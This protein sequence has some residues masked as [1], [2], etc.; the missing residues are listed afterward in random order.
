MKKQ[1]PMGKTIESNEIQKVNDAY[2]FL[3]ADLEDTFEAYRQIQFDH[4]TSVRGIGLNCS[5]TCA[6]AIGIC[7]DGNERWKSYMEDTRVF[8][9]YFGNDSQKCYYG[10][11]D[12]HHGRFAAEIAANELHHALLTDMAKFDPRTKCTCTY[13]MADSY[14]VSQYEIH[15]RAPSQ[16]SERGQMHEESANVIQQ[17]IRTCE[18]KFAELENIM[19]EKK[20]EKN[21]TE[22]EAKKDKK[23]KK[24][25]DRDPFAE[26]MSNAFVKAHKYVDYL[27]SWGKDE[28]SRVRWSGC[29]TLSCVIQNKDRNLI[30]DQT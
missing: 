28:Q 5:T 22:K 2:E 29:S 26:K 9:D 13:N 3:K 7:S 14:D 4:D 6:P 21:E 19:N 16:S 11:Y 18:E 20:K 17:I 10:I 12:G 15:S 8:Q 23:E 1:K 25:K 27:L 24:R 30:E